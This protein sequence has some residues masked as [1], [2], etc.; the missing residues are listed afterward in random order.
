MVETVSKSQPSENDPCD[1]WYAGWVE[2]Y[3]WHCGD[4][5]C[6]CTQAKIDRVTP[7]LA[8]GYPWVVRN[9]LWKG[10]FL[11]EADTEEKATQEA[12]LRGAATEHGIDLNGDLYGRRCQ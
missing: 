7:N 3:I 4:E 12:A 2:A 6:D 11:S 10:E 9:R 1:V 8:A 5:T